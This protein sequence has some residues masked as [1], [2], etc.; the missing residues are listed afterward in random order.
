M[1]L[2]DISVSWR[3]LNALSSRGHAQRN[4]ADLVIKQQPKQEEQTMSKQEDLKFWIPN[5][6]VIDASVEGLVGSKITVVDRDGGV[7]QGIIAGADPYIGLSV[8]KESDPK[9]ILLCVHGPFDPAF[10]ELFNRKDNLKAKYNKQYTPI[11]KSLFK[12]TSTGT[13]DITELF[14]EIEETSSLKGT[15]CP[16]GV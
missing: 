5:K 8:V 6:A 3:V 4:L 2:K 7:H 11:L 16:Y 1:S 13:L 12:A 9:V 10:R 14:E 15:S